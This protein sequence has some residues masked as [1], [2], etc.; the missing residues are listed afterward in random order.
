MSE[1]EVYGPFL[2]ALPVINH[3]ISEKPRVK[4]IH[5]FFE[6][7]TLFRSASRIWGPVEWGNG[8]PPP[9]PRNRPHWA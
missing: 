9:D 7:L 5:A 6:R 3:T 4:R 1:P 8:F 2:S